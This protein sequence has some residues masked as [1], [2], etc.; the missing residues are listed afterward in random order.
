[1]LRHY[2]ITALRSFWKNKGYTFLN[3]AG[4]S[5]GMAATILIILW[6]VDE[7]QYDKHWENADQIYRIA[8]HFQLNEDNYNL[9]VSA[10]PLGPL[11]ADNFPGL[12]A[13]T[14]FRVYGE[15]LMEY[16]ER[17]HIHPEFAYVDSTVFDVFSIE[18]LRGNPQ[19][20]L[21]NPNS[22]VINES[23]AR[24]IFGEEDPL[25]KRIL[26]DNLSEYRVTGVYKDIPA[27]SHF[28]FETMASMYT[29]E[30]IEASA[31]SWLLN[32]F[33]TYV[34]IRE[35]AKESDLQ[36][37]LDQ[38]MRE[39][40]VPAYSQL[41]GM[42]AEEVIQ[43][44]YAYFSIQN[45]ASI[46]LDSKLM[47]EIEANSDQQYVV[48]F[49]LIAFFLLLIACINFMNLST[50]KSEG[51]AAEVGVRKV[52]GAR[53]KQLQTQFLMETLL[54]AFMAHILAMFLVEA[55]LPAFNQLA[56]KNIQI[57]YDNL[58]FLGGLL[59]IILITGL[60]AGSYP[61]FFLSS[62]KPVVVLKGLIFKGRKKSSLRNGLIL[63]QFF[64]TT[65]LLIG[66]FVIHSQLS[67]LG[68][69]KT[70]YE[71][72]NRLILN[73][74]FT[75][76]DQA[77]S[78]KDRIQQL[79][80]VEAV[81]I[82]SYLPTPS[83]RNSWGA[84]P[85]ENP[86]E[87]VSAQYWAVDYEF[88]EALDLKM[89]TGR[90]F[91]RDYGSDSTALVINETLKE[92]FG[93]DKALGKTIMMVGGSDIEIPFTVVGVVEDF[94]FESLHSEIGPLIMHLSPSTAHVL[95]KYRE[96]DLQRVL[97]EVR[98]IWDEF[99]PGQP[100]EYSF[101]DA[102]FAS[103]YHAE[104]RT[105]AIVTVFALLA[106]FIGA[107]GLVGLAAFAA[108][109]RT[110]EIG[111]RKANGASVKRIFLILTGDFSRLVILAVLLACPL[112]WYL[113]D[114]WLDGFA[115][116]RNMPWQVFVYTAVAVLLVSFIS[117][118]WQTMRAVRRNPADSLRYE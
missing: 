101:M 52:N 14:R 44:G 43:N 23:T 46:H 94:N 56:A 4:L 20:A 57:E 71:K 42:A 37:A 72:D 60:L 73:N 91:S 117:V 111:I 11:L 29:L 51:R 1:M 80:Y 90:Y 15:T 54:L 116:R 96:A 28:H 7:K 61:A 41:M 108:E 110:K 12:E 49:S 17:V 79:P 59:S 115:Y 33:H 109:R 88:Q 103:E 50:A 64:I 98:E 31:S 5:I 74:S 78:F 38:V 87:V 65:L 34:R 89:K 26:I 58:Y 86:N 114:S 112:A 30:E 48:I 113:M 83:S 93:W 102:D 82:S 55:V 84:Y 68:K 24:N 95:I 104:R 81:T 2:F 75:L 76:R 6:V 32:N 69:V 99:L 35:D 47:A 18:L 85:R 92:R 97:A 40:T 53:R 10:Y 21:V 45:I 62:F 13:Y 16:D 106:T 19:T 100:F 9:A 67:Y 70:G 118:S 77:S 66:T 63:F 8:G 36:A 107:L 39:Y 27:T 25:G 3:I 105:S 22:M